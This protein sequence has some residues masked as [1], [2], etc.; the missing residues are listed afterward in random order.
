MWASLLSSVH[1]RKA[2]EGEDEGID[3]SVLYPE[4]IYGI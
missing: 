3:V 1:Q 2:D 4:Q